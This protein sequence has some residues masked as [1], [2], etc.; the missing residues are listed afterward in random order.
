MSTIITSPTSR[1]VIED[2][3][4]IEAQNAEG[5]TVADIQAIYDKANRE[6]TIELIEG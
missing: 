6:I 4:V 3:V 5:M 1:I 2:D